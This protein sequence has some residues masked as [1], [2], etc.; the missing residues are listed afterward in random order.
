[1]LTTTPRLAPQLTVSMAQTIALLAL[2]QGAL[3]RRLV[4]EAADNPA[5]RLGPAGR[6][7]WL[8]PALDPD[9]VSAPGDS[10][11]AHVLRQI[12]GLGLT[13]RARAIA[14]ALT[15]ALEPTGWLGSPTTRIAR[16][17]DVPEAEVLEVLARVQQIEPGGLFA[18]SLA[19][20]LRLQAHQAGD[21][22]PEMA[23]LLAALPALAAG[24][25]DAVADQTGIP[26]AAVRAAA[27]RI[28]AFD[29]K[30]GLAFGGPVL[31]SP[32]AD[33]LLR[34]QN[35]GWQAVLNPHRLMAEAAP[36]LPGSAAAAALCRALEG[37]SRIA[38][39]LGNL[40]AGQQGAWLDGGAA[41]AI[42]ARQ[43]AGSTGFHLATVNRCLTAVTARMPAGTRPL[44]SLISQP[45][46]PE[47]AAR[48]QIRARLAELLLENAHGG[49]SDAR[50][51]TLLAAEGLG[52]ARRTVAKYRAELT[53]SSPRRL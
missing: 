27:A 51:A 44:R 52:I 3:T 11:V 53:G 26:L 37:R 46:G 9:G 5:L 22:T 20:C 12:A 7:G 6:G 50:I 31:P 16:D 10:M 42:T 24:G 14:L 17:C 4:R 19:E 13:P 41:V 29:P 28:R 35:D 2:P 1:M 47:G 32:P 21:L 23:A 49:I 25:P 38:L 34:R 40:L 48:A 45:V 18:R 36:G 43:L 15:E 8:P 33:L 30:P 39:T